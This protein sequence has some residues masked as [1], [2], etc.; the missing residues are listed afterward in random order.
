MKTSYYLAAAI[1]LA[2][3]A[4]A[5]AEYTYTNITASTLAPHLDQKITLNFEFQY[6]NFGF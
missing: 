2:F 5:H 4:N 6:G 1:A 3:S